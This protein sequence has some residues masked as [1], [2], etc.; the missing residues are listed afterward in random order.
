M[1]SLYKN[2]TFLVFMKLIFHLERVKIYCTKMQIY[3][4]AK[5]K[6]TNVKQYFI[7]NEKRKGELNIKEKIDLLY[8]NIRQN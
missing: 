6:W 5:E 2:Y 7:L 1:Y 4:D 8:E 3:L